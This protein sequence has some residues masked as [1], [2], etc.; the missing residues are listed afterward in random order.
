MRSLLL[1]MAA[2]IA[3]VA[4]IAVLQ[5]SNK[6]MTPDVTVAAQSVA[7]PKPDVSVVDVLV[8]R[9][10]IPVGTVLT[11]EML[12]KQPW[13]GQLVLEGFI[14]GDTASADVIGKVVRSP[15]QAREP[16]VHSKLGGMDEPGFL[17][18]ALTPG[19]RA[20]TL[21][22]DAVS[23]VAGYIF[24]GD[25][26]DILFVHNLMGKGGS[27]SV[28]EVMASDVRVLAVNTREPG[29]ADAIVTGGTPSNVTVEV[30]ESMAQK[31]RLAEKAG[32]LSFTLRSVRSKDDEQAPEPSYVGALSRA[33]TGNTGADPV[34]IIRGANEDKDQAA[35][36]AAP[37]SPLTGIFGS[38]LGGR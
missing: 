5:W 10:A 24:P 30:D 15:I 26:V 14:T 28:S 21:T 19:M 25:H 9:E 29:A 37:A 33:G 34:R 27:P 18:A 1:L 20:V 11:Q 2:V 36:N 38:I 22:A 17:A 13:P 32:S 31:L 4:G 7:A 3:V 6:Q 23:A 12:D 16:V 35:P 8:A